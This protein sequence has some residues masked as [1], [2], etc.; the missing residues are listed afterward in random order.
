[1]AKNF[2][3]SAEDYLETVYIL[4]LKDDKPKSI[5]VATALNVSRPA[6]NIAM[7]KLIEL[8]FVNKEAYSK[9]ELTPKG[10]ALA[11]FT[12]DK[13]K[14][15][16]KFLINLGVSEKTASIDCCKIEHAI[17]PETYNIIKKYNDEH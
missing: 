7:N 15:I 3:P 12:Y 1:M 4:S 2:S 14:A 16:E 8:G 6:V 13:H 11:K 9:I 17:S 10:L 5:D